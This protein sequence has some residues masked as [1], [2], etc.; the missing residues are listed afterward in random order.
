M[1]LDEHIDDEYKDQLSE[2]HCC[3]LS[4]PSNSDNSMCNTSHAELRTTLVNR[5]DI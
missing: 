3:A 4:K 2:I 1:C 5:L